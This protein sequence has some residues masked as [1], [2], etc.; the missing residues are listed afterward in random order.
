MLVYGWRI[1][2]PAAPIETFTGPIETSS[3]Q[4][5]DI[6]EAEFLSGFAVYPPL[7]TT[8]NRIIAEAAGPLKLDPLP[9]KR[10]AKLEVLPDPQPL[11]EKFQVSKLV[12]G[13]GFV[14]TLAALVASL[15]PLLGRSVFGILR[16]LAP[17]GG[18]VAGGMWS[19]MPGWVRTALTT[20]GLAEGADFIFDLGGSADPQ[21]QFPSG[22]PP[23]AGITG[24]PS[25]IGGGLNG[26]PVV[27][28]T[29]PLTAI[30]SLGAMIQRSWTANGVPMVRL[31]NGMLGVFSKKKQRWTFRRPA[32]P[33]VLMPS[34]ASNLRTLLK[35]SR[36]VN[37]QLASLKKEIA[38][39][40]SRG[41]RRARRAAPTIVE[42]GPGSVTVK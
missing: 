29:D 14:I 25:I 3:P 20:M 31:W 32:K 28:G 16:G 41:P 30:Q 24:L 40:E 18:R 33:I 12:I 22:R 27:P 11:P 38:K 1:L 21:D 2:D 5:E 37:R 9:M 34:G 6:P 7:G 36:T 10:G 4:R 8:R 26:L 17:Q 15:G 35:A 39:S 23:S 13:G 19:R 42:T